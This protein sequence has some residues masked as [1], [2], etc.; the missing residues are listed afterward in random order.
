MGAS[1]LIVAIGFV[2][3][4]V[5]NY[6]LIPEFKKSNKPVQQNS[7]AQIE[8]TQ[9]TEPVQAEM[10]QTSTQ[11]KS[12]EPEIPEQTTK[13]KLTEPP[14]KNVKNPIEK[15]ETSTQEKS[16]KQT[17]SEKKQINLL[18]F[19]WNSL[20]QKQSGQQIIFTELKIWKQKGIIVRQSLSI[21][22]ILKS[23]ANKNL[24]F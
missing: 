1:A 11:V 8:K 23:Q 22:N 12:G 13:T 2:A 24:K 7:M 9:Q 14:T 17:A 10:Q 4:F 15:H 16:L 6:Y 21:K 3:V 20:I 5:Y 19:H 18:K